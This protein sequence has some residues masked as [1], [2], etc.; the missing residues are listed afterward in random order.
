[1]RAALSWTTVLVLAACAGVGSSPDAPAPYDPERVAFD[2]ELAVDLAVMERT[3]SGLYLQDLK[4]GDGLMAAR[5]SLVTLH[6]VGYLADGT[7]F[8]TSSGREAFQF[9]LGAD[10]VIRGWNEGIVGMKRGGIRRLVVRPSLGYRSQRFGR[11]PPNS[12]LIFDVQLLDV[13]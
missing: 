4:E 6:Y 8:D 10:E 1:M 13:R 3:A 7:L 5:R 9:R 12:T 11:I 2:P